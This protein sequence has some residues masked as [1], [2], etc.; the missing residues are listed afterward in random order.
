MAK[1]AD[2]PET[3]SFLPEVADG[4]VAH[5]GLAVSK[6]AAVPLV[7]AQKA[8]FLCSGCQCGAAAVSGSSYFGAGGVVEEVAVISMVGHSN[9]RR[10]P[11]SWFPSGT[12]GLSLIPTQT[13]H[14]LSTNQLILK[15]AAPSNWTTL[16]LTVQ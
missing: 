14:R 12:N 8:C 6:R 2:G 3:A 5:G 11:S 15:A 4:L 13:N 1:L 9:T 16:K 10:W 7:K